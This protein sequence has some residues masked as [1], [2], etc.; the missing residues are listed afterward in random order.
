MIANAKSRFLFSAVSHQIINYISI[1]SVVWCLPINPSCSSRFGEEQV[2]VGQLLK[3]LPSHSHIKLTTLQL[4]PIMHLCP[5]I[6]V[7]AKKHAHL[8]LPSYTKILVFGH[9]HSCF[10]FAQTNHNITSRWYMAKSELHFGWIITVIYFI[11]L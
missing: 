1:F 4:I 11:R 3:P 8:K 10:F 7:K 9:M 5:L 2:I 6:G